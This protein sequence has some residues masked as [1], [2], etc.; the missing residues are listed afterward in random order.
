MKTNIQMI[1]SPYA[2]KLKEDRE[3]DYTKSIY[4]NI[5]LL[6]VATLVALPITFFILTWIVD[7]L[8][9]ITQIINNL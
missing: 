5:P 6:I 2:T 8:V 4:K 7:Q 9:N 3:A 1:R